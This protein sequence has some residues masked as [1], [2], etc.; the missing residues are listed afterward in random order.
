MADESLRRALMV[1]NGSFLPMFTRPVSLILVILIAFTLLSQL[2]FMKAV[3]AWL[4]GLGKGPAPVSCEGDDK[5]AGS[6]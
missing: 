6:K 5:D 3:N 4:A 1:S 2:P